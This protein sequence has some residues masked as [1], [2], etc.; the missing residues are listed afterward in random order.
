MAD[1]TSKILFDFIESELVALVEKIRVYREKTS[2]NRQNP[3][4]PT[5]EKSNSFSCDTC[6]NTFP[7]KKISLDTF[8]EFMVKK[9]HL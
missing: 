9:I 8:F 6:H 2:I 1:E 3:S 5:S 4:P 7:T